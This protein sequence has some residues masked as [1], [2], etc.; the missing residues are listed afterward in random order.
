VL[1]G[2]SGVAVA[3][4][5]S[6]VGRSA[7][8]LPGAAAQIL[9]LLGVLAVAVLIAILPARS[10]A[11]AEWATEVPTVR[12]DHSGLRLLV[13]SDIGYDVHIPWSD[14][15]SCQIR[16]GKTGAWML[17]FDADAERVLGGKGE[18]VRRVL[19]ESVTRYGTPI[20]VNIEA[21]RRASSHS[22][23][24]L[25]HRIRG[26]SDGRVRLRPSGLELPPQA[27]SPASEHKVHRM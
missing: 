13:V 15:T 16:R 9:G 21:A 6:L 25:N 3:V 7:D 14:V 12:I 11:V 10:R 8:G 19:Q 18:P 1:A 22:V 20:A 4:V 27:E 26:L 5:A 23:L 24:W 2:I 17:C